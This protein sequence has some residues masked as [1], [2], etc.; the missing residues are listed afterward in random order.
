MILL[1]KIYQRLMAAFMS[2][3]SE[4]KNSKKIKQIH[5]A[6]KPASFELVNSAY[7][8]LVNVVFNQRRSKI[9]EVE[10]VG[11]G[12][13]ILIDEAKRRVKEN[14]EWIVNDSNRKRFLQQSSKKAASMLCNT[15]SK[16]I[17][18]TKSI[19]MPD[20]ADFYIDGVNR[21]A[22]SWDGEFCNQNEKRLLEK[23]TDFKSAVNLHYSKYSQSELKTH[24]LDSGKDHCL[25][26]IKTPSGGHT[27]IGM[28]HENRIIMYDTYH[29]HWSG[30]P[31]S[32][33][34]C[35]IIFLYWFF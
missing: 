19:R 26:R 30:V 32:S 20:F 12:C 31:L 9:P 18:F 35:T 16:Y 33:R 8:H 6:S 2:W 23:Y 17:H 29:N 34:K 1:T 11:N 24:F 15:I 22:F 3:L 28:K 27:F 7:I 4:K 25:L 21:N 10:R 14:P 13:E 5:Q